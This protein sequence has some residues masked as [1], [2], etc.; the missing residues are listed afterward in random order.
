MKQE[1]QKIQNKNSL[2][3]EQN[4]PNNLKDEANQQEETSRREQEQKIKNSVIDGTRAIMH[5]IEPG[6]FKMGKVGKTVDVTLTKPFD[7]M[8]TP[9]TQIIWRKIAELVSK[10]PKNLIKINPDPSYFKGDMRPLENVTF[11]EILIWISGLNELSKAGDPALE[12]LISGHKK[13]DVYRLPT[14]AEWEFVIRGRGQFNDNYHFG[15]DESLLG[16]YAWYYE[17]SDDKTHPV[18]MKKP[19]KF[20]NKEFFDMHGNVAEA[21]QDWYQNSLSGGTDPQGAKIG[22]SRV[23]RGGSWLHETKFVVSGERS[24]GEPDDEPWD[25]QGFRLARTVRPGG[26]Q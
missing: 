25:G 5:R 24:E 2:A 9:V 8:A 10:N 26:S 18:A 1:I 4:D 17:N 15:N 11:K 13:G 6:S 14:E 3:K 12:D 19:L 22:P 23:F 21:T 16:D 7:M 20:E